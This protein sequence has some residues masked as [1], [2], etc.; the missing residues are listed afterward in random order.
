MEGN[1]ADSGFVPVKERFAKAKRDQ[2]QKEAEKL[3]RIR[4]NTTNNPVVDGSNAGSDSLRRITHSY[5]HSI[6]CRRQ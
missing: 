2:Q 6:A 1:N 4:V 3:E 5:T